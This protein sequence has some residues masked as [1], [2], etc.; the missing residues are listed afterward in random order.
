MRS[1]LGT[2]LV[3]TFS[4]ALVGL[5]GPAQ[6]L[7]EEAPD[8]AAPTEVALGPAEDA[9][10][11][12]LVVGTNEGGPGQARLRYAQDDAGRVADLLTTLGGYPAER[13]ERLLA[14]SAAEL[15]SALSRVRAELAAHAARGEKSRFFFYYSGHARADAL[16][17]GQQQVALSELRERVLSLPATVSLVVLDACQS[18]AFSR[19]KGA[20]PAADFSWNSVQRLETEGVAVIASS[21]GV[22]LSQESDELK[23]GYFTHHFLVSLRGAGDQNADGRVTLSEAYQYAYNRTLAATAATAVGEQHATLETSF[24]GKGDLEL[25]QPAKADARLLLPA[26]FAG[27]I[28]VQSLPSYSPLAEVQK[29]SGQPVELALPAG[30]YLATLREGADVLRCSVQLPSAQVT[31]FAQTSCVRRPAVQAQAKGASAPRREVVLPTPT[32]EE[33]FFLEL[34][35]GYGEPT[36]DGAYERRLEAFD[37]ERQGTDDARYSIAVGYRLQRHLAAGLWHFNMDGA[38]Y[39]RDSGSA[40]Q[41]FVWDSQALGAFVQVDY[42]IGPLRNVNLFARGGGGLALA[43]TEFDAIKTNVVFAGEDPSL[44]DLSAT[45]ERVDDDFAGYFLTLGAGVQIM[46][47]EVFGFTLEGRYTFSPVLDNALGDVRDVG[48][49]AVLFGLRLRTWE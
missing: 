35:Y 29:A 33:G 17:L 42:G 47:F 28:L 23:S 36:G 49:L 6:A 30:R 15:L 12:A 24:K 18:G 3:T 45:T 38:D 5:F 39:A 44:Q 2:R 4:L 43:S 8:D 48:G 13:I 16:N 14:P 22:E 27:R 46:P 32:G 25:T 37:F 11:Y 21:T 19:V 34:T 20:E 40:P 41:D 26:A 1:W 10:R 7:A 31:T 9:A